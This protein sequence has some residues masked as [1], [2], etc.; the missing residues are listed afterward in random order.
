[1]LKKW[2]L[3][4]EK[5]RFVTTGTF[6]MALRYAIFVLIGVWFGINHYQV[7]LLSTWL[8]SSG[9]AFLS[10]KYLVFCTK[11]NHIKE[12]LKSVLI[13]VISYFINAVLL[14][15]GVGVCKLNTYIMQAIAVV[16]IVVIN[17][18]LFKYFAFK[19][20]KKTW[21]EKIYNLWS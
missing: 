7:V 12:F 9:L 19:Q 6:N 4:D 8:L 11:G 17:Y 10:Y 3:L 16:L 5:I 15:L 13:W 1:M 2:F 18:M 21:L 20:R 14:W